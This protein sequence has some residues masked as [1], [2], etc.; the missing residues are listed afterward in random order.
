MDMKNTKISTIIWFI[1]GAI[2][3]LLVV[4]FGRFQLL[5]NSNLVEKNRGYAIEYKID[6]NDRMSQN[7]KVSAD[8]KNRGGVSPSC[9]PEISKH[10]TASCP[11]PNPDRCYINGV[12]KMF[13]FPF[14]GELLEI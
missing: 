10:S 11:V 13:F 3:L 2:I 7:I 12:F 6:R 14:P 1:L 5:G 4:D 9:D 8:C